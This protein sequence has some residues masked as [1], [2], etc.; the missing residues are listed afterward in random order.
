MVGRAG[1]PLSDG[2]LL[3]GHIPHSTVR[4]VGGL[5]T[6]CYHLGAH[7]SRSSRSSGKSRVSS[8]SSLSD[9]IQPGG[10]QIIQSMLLTA[11]SRLPHYHTKL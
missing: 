5:Q 4:E 8:S 11:Y 2:F 10:D 1:G 9:L 6:A 3:L 7:V